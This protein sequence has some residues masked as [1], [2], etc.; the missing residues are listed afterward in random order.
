MYKLDSHNCNQSRVEVINQLFRNRVKQVIANDQRAKY[1]K[2]GKNSKLINLIL[3]WSLGP[4]ARPAGD[5]FQKSVQIGRGYIGA[6]SATSKL[7]RCH[8]CG[9]A[10]GRLGKKKRCACKKTVQCPPWLLG[11]RWRQLR[12]VDVF[13]MFASYTFWLMFLNWVLNVRSDWQFL[14]M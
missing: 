2:V 13:F 7:A 9:M 10:L 11:S 3:I 12:K 4:P 14:T 1:S 8:I 5:H 6:S